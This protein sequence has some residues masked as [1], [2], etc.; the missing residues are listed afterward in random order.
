MVDFTIK[1]SIFLLEKKN[2]TKIYSETKMEG[3]F[4]TLF[5]G[6]FLTILASRVPQVSLLVHLV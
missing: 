1:N 2:E 4:S 5:M 3:V 6:A